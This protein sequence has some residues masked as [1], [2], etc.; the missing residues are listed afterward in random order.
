MLLSSLNIPIAFTR[1]LIQRQATPQSQAKSPQIRIVRAQQSHLE[2]KNKNIYLVLSVLRAAIAAFH[3]WRNVI[4]YSQP[5]RGYHRCTHLTT[6]TKS[7]KLWPSK[8][9][10]REPTWNN[11]RQRCSIIMIGRVDYICQDS[12][13]FLYLHKLLKV[14]SWSIFTFKKNKIKK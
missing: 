4:H 7:K 2:Y 3:L 14:L 9:S 11:Y 12:V 10:L 6:G 8:T 13:I 1:K 5:T